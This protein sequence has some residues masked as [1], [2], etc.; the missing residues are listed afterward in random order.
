MV[1]TNLAGLPL[2]PLPVM[3]TDLVYVAGPG[4]PPDDYSSQRA[5]VGDIRTV[6][7]YG[8]RF[9]LGHEM[10][11]DL[12]DPP[13]D[14]PYLPGGSP[15]AILLLGFDLDDT[16][17]FAFVLP[18]EYKEET[19]IEVNIH[20]TPGASGVDDFNR[21]V[22]WQLDVASASI[23]DY[24]NALVSTEL[25]TACS[26]FDHLR[27]I[28]SASAVIPGAG[29]L[30]IGTVIHGVLYRTAVGPGQDEFGAISGA[31]PL[32]VGLSFSYQIDRLGSTSPL[33]K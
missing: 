32:V 7:R 18:E 2:R 20:W 30:K 31:L 3:D 19:D 23:A 26:G 28:A 16:A 25:N 12:T 11:K 8:S 9:V 15:P 4:V 22:T 13:V 14:T 6:E 27:E 33:V 24:Y 5:T 29:V 17:R 21:S 10:T 1:D